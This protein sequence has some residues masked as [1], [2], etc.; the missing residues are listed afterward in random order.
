MQNIVNEN[1]KKLACLF[2]E[3][4]DKYMERKNDKDSRG[5]DFN[6]KIEVYF[7]LSKYLKNDYGYKYS[8]YKNF[9]EAEKKEGSI[10]I[11]I[12]SKLMD[13]YLSH[14]WRVR[15]SKISKNIKFNYYDEIGDWIIVLNT[16]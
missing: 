14:G 3:G 11:I 5:N 2:I 8:K 16:Y 7:N 15:I 1:R 6:H 12:R 9:F 10:H 13:Y 4:I